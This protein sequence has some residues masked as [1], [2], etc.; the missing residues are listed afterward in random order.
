[1]VTGYRSPVHKGHSKKRLQL[2]C[3]AHTLTL[4]LSLSEFCA[5]QLQGNADVGLT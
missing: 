1:M 4:L 5:E 2:S 3:A